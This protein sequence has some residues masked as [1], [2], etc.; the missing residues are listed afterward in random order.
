MPKTEAE[1]R[2]VRK[3]LDEGA[4]FADFPD[5]VTWAD[6]DAA[7]KLDADPFRDRKDELDARG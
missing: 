4:T 6:V 2:E 5:G 1:L 7:E 3:L